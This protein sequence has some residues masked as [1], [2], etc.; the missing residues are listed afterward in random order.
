MD[1]TELKYKIIKSLRQ[2]GFRVRN[3]CAS[4]PRNLSKEKIRV[5]HQTSVRHRLDKAK[6]GLHKKEQLLLARI[7]SGNDIDPLKIRPRLVEVI[8]GSED[9]L[10]FRYASLH[11]SIPVSSGYGRRLRFLVVD[12]NNDKLLGLIGLG[13]PVFSLRPRDNWVEWSLEDRKSRLK[14]VIDAFVLGAV[15]PYSFLLCGKLVAMLVASN[16]VRDAFSK[17]Y[18]GKESL[19]KQKLYDG[20]LAMLTTTSAL[21]RSSLYN[22]LKFRDSLLYHSV[23]FTR[24][25]GEFHF[26]NGLYREI[27]EFATKHCKPTAKQKSW[28][29]GFRNRREVIKKCLPAMGL[30][31]ELL[32]HGIE[33]EVFVVPLAS[34]CKEFL[35]GKQSR[36]RYNNMS[37]FE[38]FEYFRERWLIPKYKR[39]DRYKFWHPD[40]WVI[41]SNGK[42]SYDR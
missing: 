12:E 35:C 24:G 30:S 23:G 37:V 15:P 5:L 4:P 29:T 2:Q 7:A 41:W 8:T 38:I 19:I 13:D 42:V 31:S 22:R 40:E 27:T 28:G 6:G 1:A 14:Y 25:S 21:G 9:E 33:R 18:R 32:Y 34:N 3:G 20:K 39:D 26:T 16:E 11:W 17:K 36:L 10:L